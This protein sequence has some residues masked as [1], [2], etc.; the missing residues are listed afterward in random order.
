MLKRNIMRTRLFGLICL[1]LIS[2]SIVAYAE[3]IEQ[4]DVETQVTKV[5]DTINNGGSATPTQA[6]TISAGPLTTATINPGV[7]SQSGGNIF[8]EFLESAITSFGT[9]IQNAFGVTINKDGSYFIEGADAIE[10][11]NVI[12]TGGSGITYSDGTLTVQQADSAII[13][14]NPVVNLEELTASG[15]TFSVASA[16]SVKLD[17]A[18]AKNVRDS[19]FVLDGNIA[20]S[21]AAG[22]SY[23]IADCA[24]LQLDYESI[25]TPNS[26]VMTKDRINPSYSL[27]GVALNI[28]SALYEWTEFINSLN[29]TFVTLNREFGVECIDIIPEGSYS[30]SEYEP[31]TDFRLST[32]GVQHKTCFRKRASQT[33]PLPAGCEQCTFV[34]LIEKKIE[35]NGVVDYGRNL[36][37]ASFQSIESGQKFVFRN[38]GA[39]SLKLDGVLLY[40]NNL[41][42]SSDSPVYETFASNFLAIVEKQT[43][44]GTHRLIGISEKQSPLSVN[45]IKNYATSYSA[46]T[47]AI[48]DNSLEYNRGNL[49]VRVLPKDSAEINSMLNS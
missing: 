42:V 6:V 24:G 12:I 35:S 4:E 23:Q 25:A 32:R 44:A 26:L 22:T 45:I 19:S 27:K 41:I 9:L 10:Q 29:S 34:D 5:E 7:V 8:I 30:Y 47:L 46:A 38:N 11:G 13:S 37:D 20:I 16:D 18:M 21:S 40:I 48:D 43:P 49:K 14:N 15:S 28:T 1:L 17:C 3:N 36:F 39:A 2:L 33:N 31:T